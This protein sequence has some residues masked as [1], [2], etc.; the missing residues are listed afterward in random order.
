VYAI[1]TWTVAWTVGTVVQL[2]L[3]WPLTLGGQKWST[4]LPGLFTAVK[5]PR[6]P[7]DYE[8]FWIPKPVWTILE[9]IKISHPH[10]DSKTGPSSLGFTH[11]TVYA[12][13]AV[14]LQ[15]AVKQVMSFHVLSR[16]ANRGDGFQTRISD[17]KLGRIQYCFKTKHPL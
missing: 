14:T 17:K 9:K 12:I 2:H 7:V 16:V 4:S 15:F 10:W 8:T 1:K 5:Y 13:S 6:V 11:Y 3:R